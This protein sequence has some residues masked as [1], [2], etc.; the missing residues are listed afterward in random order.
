MAIQTIEGG[1][2]PLV[3]VL[4]SPSGT[5]TIGYRLGGF[6][7]GPS[8]VVAGYSP[9]AGAVYDRLI[10]LPTI[11]W[12]RGTLTLIFLD[13]LDRC[14]PVSSTITDGVQ[15]PNELHFL[16]SN[17]DEPFNEAAI[18]SGYWSTLRLCA[19]LGMIA[20]RGIPRS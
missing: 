5:S 10:S 8:V 14:G 16:P 6:N 19:S 18:R 12:M 3:E 11:S 17:F 7:A 13:E 15:E 9:I 4:T 1:Q 2:I 20:G